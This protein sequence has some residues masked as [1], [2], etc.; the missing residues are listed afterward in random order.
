MYSQSIQPDNYVSQALPFAADYGVA[1]GD[2]EIDRY[3]E[4]VGFYFVDELEV[5]ADAYRCG[6]RAAEQTVVVTLATAHTIAGT[7]VG[8]SRNYDKVDL[9][10]VYSI[11]AI[12][13]LDAECA[14]MHP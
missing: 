1:V 6:S 11:V 7:V 8:Y 2:N 13:F 9:R 5:I 10:N 4:F 3:I 14:K 12:R